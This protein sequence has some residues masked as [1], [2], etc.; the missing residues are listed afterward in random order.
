MI[1]P[2]YVAQVHTRFTK[3]GD[4]LMPCHEYCGLGHSQMLA[5]V[6][7]VPPDQ[8]RPDAEGRADLWRRWLNALR[9]RRAGASPP[10]PA[11][12][13]CAPWSS[14]MSGW[15]S[16]PSPSPACSASGRCGRAARS[17]RRRTPPSNYFRAVTLHGVSMAFVLT[18]FF[19]MG[20]G[21]FTAETALRR[22]LPGLRFAWAAFWMGLAGTF[23]AAL[24]VISGNASVLYTFYPPMTATA[25]FYIGLVLVVVG[26]WIWCLIMIVAMRQWK[27]A[28][29]GQPVPLAMFATVANAV[30]W[31]WT[32]LGV[33]VELL[34][35]VIPPRSASTAWS[36]SA[37]RA[38]SF[39]GRCTR[40]SISGSSPAIS[41]STPWRRGRPAAGSIP[42]PWAA[43]PSSS[44]SST[45][46][47][48]ACITCSW[49]R[50]IPTASS[51]SR[52]S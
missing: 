23:M 14:P 22:P 27:A 28:N 18:T 43:S 48:S 21:Y 49:T 31:L 24:A 20:F 44:S 30:M 1:I 47:R 4:L 7:V 37:C 45:R 16:P 19:I 39:P 17:T 38:P 25:W 2:G 12:C 15:P 8:F 9:Q 41:L 42:T 46:C 26:S 52:C 40:S 35:Q 5:T 33:A 6:K 10:P 3:T 29:P 32:T 36:T 11:S 50:S 34:F 51:S 13:P